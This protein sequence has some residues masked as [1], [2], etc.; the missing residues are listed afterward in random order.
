MSTIQ[1]HPTNHEHAFVRK[2]AYCASQAVCMRHECQ[3]SSAP[4][5][6]SPTRRRAREA[7]R[8]SHS[9]ATDVKNIARSALCSVP[10]AEGSTCDTNTALTHAAPVSPPHAP[11]LKAASCSFQLPSP[12]SRAL[13]T[14][15]ILA[16]GA[17]W[18]RCHRTVSTAMA[19]VVAVTPSAYHR[20]SHGY[21]SR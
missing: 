21:V 4:S 13:S 18:R 9:S 6:S 20:S 17:K 16:F 14:S 12:F 15:E 19:D 7:G 3:S 8:V 11:S 1:L 5:P 2:V 10:S